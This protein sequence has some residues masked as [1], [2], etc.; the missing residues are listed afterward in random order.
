M[1]SRSVNKVILVGRLGKD[2]ETKFTASGVAKTTFSVATSRRWKDQQ[3]GEW[4]EETDWHN[5]VLWRSENVA[6]YLTKG[7]QVYVEG[8][9]STRSY[10]DKEGNKKWITEVVGDDV[11]LLGGRGGEGESGG[12]SGEEEFGAGPVSMP[13]GSQPRQR[14]PATQ[15]SNFDGGITDD[16]VPF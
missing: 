4:K 12:G 6:N 9:L 13:R 15:E 1:A 16:D 7:K 14:T 5:I 3:S 11:I 2:A 8:R 10:D